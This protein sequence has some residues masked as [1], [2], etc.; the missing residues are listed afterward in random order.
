MATVKK[1][2]WTSAKGEIKEGWRVAYT[3]NTGK[4]RFKQFEK[5]RD[6]DAYRIKAEGEVSLGIHT[7]DAASITV[8]EACDIWVKK[9]IAEDLEWGTI[10]QRKEL[11]NLHIKPLIGTEKLSRLKM[12]N[13]EA[14]RD[15]L[16]ETR[17][18]IMAH[19]VTR[20]LS[21][22]LI[23]AMRQGL[24]AQNVASDV[25]V[26]M[27]GRDE[28]RIEIP[29]KAVLRSM[30]DAA[31]RLDNEHP[32]TYPLIL[33]AISAGLRSSEL[34]GLRWPDL[35]LK[36]QT[37]TVRQRADQRGIL[38]KCK[39]KAAYRTIPIA[40]AV[41]TAL[42][43]WRLRC[44]PSDLNLVF[45][46]EAGRP[47]FPNNLR[48]VRWLPVLKAIGAATD[49]GKKDR[50]GRKVWDL[51]WG[52]HD[53]R[54]ACASRWIKQKIDLKRLTTWLGHS[55]VAI[56]LDIYGHLI[57]DEE[58]DAAIVAAASAELMA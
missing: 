25:T 55:S 48:E 31:M 8:A 36:A 35:D 33:L 16:I 27:R 21:S 47:I 10:K 9:G 28:A 53:L 30:L 37:L 5:K 38:G 32:E 51:K 49:T 46:N 58:E 4:R 15:S 56:T 41:V 11:C 3:D 24:V 40:A 54:H 6:A 57:K 12:P 50:K 20:A 2:T 23:E 43:A 34:R 13:I 26:K 52:L 19:K 17:S 44:P 22:V 39:S 7:A 42:K 29:D 1:R 45:P 18:R 14:F